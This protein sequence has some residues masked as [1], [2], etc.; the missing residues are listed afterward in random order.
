MKESRGPMR[1]SGEKRPEPVDEGVARVGIALSALGRNLWV[2][3]P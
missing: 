2:H 3:L 1:G